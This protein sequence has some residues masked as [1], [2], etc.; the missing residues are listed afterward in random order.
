MASGLVEHTDNFTVVT[1]LHLIIDLQQSGIVNF[2]VDKY[3]RVINL[4]DCHIPVN[5]ESVLLCQ[6][7]RW[8]PF[9]LPS[10]FLS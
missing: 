1:N 4:T 10:L 3:H 9:S 7:I 2:C 5:I 8:L 6:I